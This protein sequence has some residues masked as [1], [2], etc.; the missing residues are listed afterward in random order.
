V[1]YRCG[2]RALDIAG[3]LLALCALAIPMLVIAV[4]IKGGGNGTVLFRQTRV[5]RGGRLFR[6]FKFRTMTASQA[7]VNDFTPGDLRRLTPLGRRLRATKADE[8][9]QLFNVLLGHMSFVG[10]R[11]EVPEYS[12]HLSAADRALVLSTRPG[13]TD[14]ASLRFFDEELLLASVRCPQA[15]YVGVIMPKKTRY[16]RFYVRNASIATDAALVLATARMLLARLT[17]RR[18]AI[19]A[20]A[21]VERAADLVVH[22]HI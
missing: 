1:L 22:R 6:I 16:A 14:F 17:P 8:L 20:S 10:P 13:L 19:D 11:P 9:P 12:A 3:A 15:Y 2:K 18:T 21:D 4:A 7:D 5:G